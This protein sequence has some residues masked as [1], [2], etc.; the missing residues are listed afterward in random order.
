M[1]QSQEKL[2]TDRKTD[3]R[4]DGRSDIRMDRRM[5]GKTDR[6][7]FTGPSGRGQGSIK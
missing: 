5:D 2:R 1:S 3:R 7:Y 6:P 4:M